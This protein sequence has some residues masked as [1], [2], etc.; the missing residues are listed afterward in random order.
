M[1]HYVQRFKKSL[2]NFRFLSVENFK[3]QLDF[4]EKNF[5]FL[6][7]NEWKYILKNNCVG[8][9]KDK[10][11]LTFDDALKCHYEY[12]YPELKKRGLWEF[13]IYQ[14]NHIKRINYWMCIE[15]IYYV[16]HIKKGFT[17]SFKIFSR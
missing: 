10:I 4:F 13:S 16:A 8:N 5:G 7:R 6:E 9:Y 3:K 2:P 12:V 1:Y 17:K 11:I 14:L 15:F